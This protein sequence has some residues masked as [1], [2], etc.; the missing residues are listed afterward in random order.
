MSYPIWS[1]PS[2]FKTGIKNDMTYTLVESI[3]ADLTPLRDYNDNTGPG[4]SSPLFKEHH[5]YSENFLPEFIDNTKETLDLTVMYWSLVAGSRTGPGNNY[6]ADNSDP[7]KLCEE[8]EP[9]V[10][11]DAAPCPI[12]EPC[13]TGA[14]PPLP[15]KTCPKGCT[16]KNF[17][18]PAQWASFNTDWGKRLYTSLEAAAARGVKIRIIQAL[19]APTGRFSWPSGEGRTLQAKY[20]DSIKI[21]FWT[22]DSPYCGP[23]IST[24]L[25]PPSCSQGSTIAP[26]NWYGGWYNRGITHCKLWIADK[27]KCYIGSLNMDWRSFSLVKE[28]GIVLESKNITNTKPLFQD[29]ENLYEA[30]WQMAAPEV[31]GWSAQAGQIHQFPLPIS[32]ILGQPPVVEFKSP[33]L[34]PR[35]WTRVPNWSKKIPGG[36]RGPNLAAQG[37]PPA[38]SSADKPLSLILSGERG[39][40]FFTAS[41]TESKVDSRTWDQDG[42]VHTIRAADKFVHISL[43]TYTPD[44]PYLGQT[45][46][47]WWPAFWNAILHAVFNKGAKVKIILSLWAGGAWQAASFHKI[48]EKIGTTANP[49]QL[50]IRYFS[51]PGWDKTPSG[52]SIEHPAGPNAYLPPKYPPFTRVNHTKYFVTDKTANIGTSNWTRSYFAGTLGMSCNATH[53]GI[54]DMVNEI[55]FRDWN[56]EYVQPINAKPWCGSVRSFFPCNGCNNCLK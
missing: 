25:P 48:L 38:F 34:H 22:A 56:S 42:I 9:P 37:L 5:A 7:H 31:S 51:M 17:F 27:K 49:D 18:T 3:P 14:A 26:P 33:D 15:Q 19:P 23:P 35:G 40:F 41:P 47:L 20:P 10:G 32:G 55:F 21:R 12:S 39:D 29:L 28:L 1:L 11:S 4:N 36:P 6:C 44:A 30:W 2:K 46:D 50:Q 43:M 53:V 45:G 8:P 54:C 16:L 52:G 13:S 24:S